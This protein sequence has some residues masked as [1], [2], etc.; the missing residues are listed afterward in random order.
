[1]S[2]I[3][4]YMLEQKLM[5]TAS[6]FIHLEG[7]ISKARTNFILIDIMLKFKSLMQQ[8]HIKKHNKHMICLF[9]LKNNLK[10]LR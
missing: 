1:M 4:L 9:I 2:M 3:A 7:L 8:K 10:Y 5:I 6:L